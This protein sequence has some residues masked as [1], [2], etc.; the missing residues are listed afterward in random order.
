MAR[1]S[2]AAPT[3]V[4]DESPATPD[5]TLGD[6]LAPTRQ[7]R[8][9]STPIRRS[10]LQD[11]EGEGVEAPLR[12][13]VKERRGLALDLLMLLHCTASAEPWDVE[14]P[15]MAWARALDM[16]LTS[17]SE[18]TV[19]KNW[20]WL[21]DKGLIHSERSHRFRRVFMLM[22]DGSGDEYSR[23]DGRKRGFFGLPFVYFKGRWHKELSL[24]G[25]SVLF[26]ALAQPPTFNLITERAAGWYGVSADSL[27]RGLDE[28]RDLGLLKTWQVARKTSRAR[29]GITRVNHY[30]LNPPFG[31]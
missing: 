3:S 18:T 10:F 27:Q 16:P 30:H 25:K 7:R 29:Y 1:K 9:T 8:R 15:A 14:M 12:W 13:F 17:G 23:P 2:K 11:T 19:S 22:E 31:S 21:E 28:L 26:I 20:S 6:L 4:E 5:E 24:T